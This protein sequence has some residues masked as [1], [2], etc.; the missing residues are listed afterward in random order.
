MTKGTDTLGRILLKVKSNLHQDWLA[1]SILQKICGSELN[2]KK[3]YYITTKMK[4]PKIIAK[5]WK[6]PEEKLL[7]IVLKVLQD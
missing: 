2:K 3:H 5:M 1:T 6:E 4:P 7:L